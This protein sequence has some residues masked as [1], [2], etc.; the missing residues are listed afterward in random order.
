MSGQV[1]STKLTVIPTARKINRNTHT[2]TSPPSAVTT[3]L[4]ESP[5]CAS[6]YSDDWFGVLTRGRS[7][8]HLA[9]LE[10][11][12]IHVQRPDL[13]KQKQNVAPLLLLKSCF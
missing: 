4:V 9:V 3:H 5:K 12:Y 7:A 2:S 1:S 13:C 11:V 10:S 8:R 6:L